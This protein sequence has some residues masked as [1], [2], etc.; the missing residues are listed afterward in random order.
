[1]NGILIIMYNLDN[2]G[3]LAVLSCVN[4]LMD[5]NEAQPRRLD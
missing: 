1:M 2:C 5:E 3:S 4:F